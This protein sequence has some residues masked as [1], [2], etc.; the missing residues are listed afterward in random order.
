MLIHVLLVATSLAVPIETAPLVQDTF[1]ITLVNQSAPGG[2]SNVIRIE[3]DHLEFVQWSQIVLRSGPTA[4]A[5]FQIHQVQ[6]VVNRSAGGA[7]AFEMI[8]HTGENIEVRADRMMPQ[9]NNVILFY[10]GD[11]IVGLASQNGAKMVI[12]KSARIDGADGS[13]RLADPVRHRNRR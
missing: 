10:T 11:R 6:L 9:Q 12:D 1:E 3:A 8:P 5:A 13:A 2:P 4:V 7:R